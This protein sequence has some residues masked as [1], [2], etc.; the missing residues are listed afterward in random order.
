MILNLDEIISLKN[1]LAETCGVTLHLHDACGS[2]SFSF[3]NPVSEEVQNIV[4]ES[5]STT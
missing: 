1:Q 2:Q 3:D 4:S 5:L